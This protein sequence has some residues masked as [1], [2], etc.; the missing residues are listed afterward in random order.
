LLQCSL[1]VFGGHQLTSLKRFELLTAYFAFI[2]LLSEWRINFD[3][4][5]SL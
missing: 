3:T 4:E 1:H 2:S 5:Q